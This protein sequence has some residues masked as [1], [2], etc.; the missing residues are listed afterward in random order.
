MPA[1]VTEKQVNDSDLIEYFRVKKNILNKRSE[2]RYQEM[3]DDGIRMLEISEGLNDIEKIAESND[4]LGFIY[5]KIGDEDH[6]PVDYFERSKSIREDLFKKDKSKASD[7]ALS[8]CNLGTVYLENTN[9]PSDIVQAITYFDEAI[10][11]QEDIYKKTKNYNTANDLAVSYNYIGYAYLHIGENNEEAIEYFVKAIDLQNE[12]TGKTAETKSDA[13]LSYSYFYIGSAYFTIGNINKGFSF[14]YKAMELRKDI[15]KKTPNL[16]TSADLAKTYET[17]GMKYLDMKNAIDALKYF[18][19]AIELRENIYNNISNRK[20]AKNL[21][22]LYDFIGFCNMRK[23][24]YNKWHEYR[25][26]ALKLREKYKEES[27]ESTLEKSRI[28]YIVKKSFDDLYKHGFF[29]EDRLLDAYLRIVENQEKIY[30]E[31]PNDS[32][33]KSLL[34]SYNKI[35]INNIKKGNF[36]NANYYLFE[37][38]K[39]SNKLYDRIQNIESNR[40]IARSN[41]HVGKSFIEKGLTNQ[42]IKYFEKSTKLQLKLIKEI[43]NLLIIKELA[44][45]LNSIGKV[46]LLLG[47][48]NNAIEYFEKA[49]NYAIISQ[50][51]NI[52]NEYISDLIE[53]LLLSSKISLA[54]D[55][56]DGFISRLDSINKNSIFSI[57]G[58]IIDPY[59]IKVNH[60]HVK[61]NVIINDF[62]SAFIASERTRARSF[63]N[64]I[65]F[66]TA[67]SNPNIDPIV[68][69]KLLTLHY[70]ISNLISRK[71]FMSISENYFDELKYIE[72]R[73]NNKINKFN[74]IDELLSK[75]LEYSKLKN[76]KLADLTDAKKL[77]RINKAIL[78]YVIWEEDDPLHQSY[79]IVITPIGEKIV[80]LKKDF[81][82]TEH[83][84][85]FHTLISNPQSHFVHGKNKAGKTKLFPLETRNPTSNC[86]TGKDCSDRVKGTLPITLLDNDGKIY[87]AVWGKNEKNNDYILEKKE[88]TGY[89]TIVIYNNKDRLTEI[90]KLSALL[91]ENLIA[92]AEAAL[93]ELKYDKDAKELIIIPDG[94]LALLPFD[95]LRQNKE[96]KYLIERYDFT[97]TPSVSVLKAVTE[98]II[99]YSKEKRNDLIAFVGPEYGAINPGCTGAGNN[100]LLASN[101]KSSLPVAVASEIEL[102]GPYSEGSTLK[103]YKSREINFAN[104]C[105]AKNES[106]S[107]ESIFRIT[108]SVLKFFE[109]IIDRV[110]AFFNENDHRY[111]FSGIRIIS[112]KDAREDKIKELSENGTLEKY[113]VVH[114]STHGFFATDY[115]PFTSLIFSETSNKNE[116]ES[117][118]DKKDKNVKKHDDGYLTVGE[119]GILRLK[120]DLVTLSACETGLGD[121]T[122]GEGFIGFIRA[123]H[124]AGANAVSATLW[125]VDETATLLITENVYKTV[126]DKKIGYKEAYAMAKKDLLKKEKYKDPYYWSSFSVYGE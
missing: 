112:G 34:I 77:C 52:I 101:T 78:D 74:K 48:N 16:K 67:L 98:R 61:A 57:N 27:F 56:L 7:L 21:E 96:S 66:K 73:I 42:A 62:S 39:I 126:R 108:N 92:P 15:Y 114:F 80:T 105:L 76:P 45:S 125:K 50:N 20:T 26:K 106:S 124:V 65:G 120:A 123:F 14:L 86:T 24:D 71:N 110:I 23:G 103:Y 49:F 94:P 93:K 55:K 102:N 11:L 69:T 30:L 10:R 35:A 2:G 1:G 90:D 43:D 51:K 81:P 60:Y 59:W 5:F 29:N 19:K 116:N 72:W 104:L 3:L 13:D 17:I 68:R 58:F 100:Y 122:D 9:I 79:C 64:E 70:E 40:E 32:I 4:L 83:I 84:E 82:Y 121:K 31:R 63:L 118:D 89:Y 119:A 113:K 109:N 46:Y 12:F 25:D 97:L 37:A 22:F 111:V 18:T 88:D 47:N 53:A 54:L 28:N 33:A 85:R 107:L 91:Y 44:E 38:D 117:K 6:R 8:L 41:Y 75:N 36:S 95:A 99:D 87:N 115:T